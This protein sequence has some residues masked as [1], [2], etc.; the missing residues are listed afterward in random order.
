[1][2]AHVEGVN[3]VTADCQAAAERAILTRRPGEN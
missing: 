2:Q 1:M 3:G